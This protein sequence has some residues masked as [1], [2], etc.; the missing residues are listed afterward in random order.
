MKGTSYVVDQHESTSYVVDQHESTS[1]VVD[2]HE[3][4]ELCSGPAWKVRVM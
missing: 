4:Y 3:R 2:Q 1:Y